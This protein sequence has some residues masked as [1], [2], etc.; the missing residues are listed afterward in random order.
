MA[1]VNRATDASMDTSTGMFAPQ[2]AGL[3]AGENIDRCACCY[4]KTSDGKVFMS[5]GTAANEAAE[6]AGMSAKA[7]VAGRPVTLFGIGA[8]FRYAA[9]GLG[10]GDKYFVA[11]T[12]G[13][14]DT[15]ATIGGTVPVA[16]AIDDTDI[17][18]IVNYT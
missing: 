5:N 10:P 14:L 18:L 7:A 11:A 13:R 12:P 16:Q 1:L 9:S 15:A 2:I 17:R 4:I 3:I 6:F 8:R